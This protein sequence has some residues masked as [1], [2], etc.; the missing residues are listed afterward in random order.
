MMR[1]RRNPVCLVVLC[2]G[3]MGLAGQ[4]AAAPAQ[5]AESVN[6]IEV[7]ENVSESIPGMDGRLSS[8]MNIILLLTVLSIA[9]SMLILCTCFTRIVIETSCTAMLEMSSRV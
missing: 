5:G 7:L 6:P 4:A 9:P 2:I 3:I 1:V 8:T